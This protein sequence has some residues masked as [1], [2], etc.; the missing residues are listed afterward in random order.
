[1]EPRQVLMTVNDWGFDFEQSQRIADLLRNQFNEA[2][3]EVEAFQ[4]QGIPF[5][6]YTVNPDFDDTE[7]VSTLDE[8]LEAIIETVRMS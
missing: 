7:F 8:S 3:L 5:V 6:R 1:M 2:L 4:D